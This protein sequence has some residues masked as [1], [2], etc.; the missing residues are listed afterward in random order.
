MAS[1]IKGYQRNAE[2]YERRW[3]TAMREGNA[4]EAYAAQE[5]YKKNIEKQE[6]ELKKMDPNSK[7]YE[8]AERSIEEQKS[9]A[10]E[11][12]RQ[13]RIEFS[14]E[15]K[16]E[17]YQQLNA[18]NM[19]ISHDMSKAVER[20]DTASYDFLRSQYEKNIS[21]QEQLG[22][23]MKEEGVDFQDT[24][25]REKVDL[26]DH[27]IDMRNKLNEQLAEKEA[28]GKKI[29]EEERANASKYSNQVKKDEVELVKYQNDKK[30]ESMRERGA[31][32]EEIKA[33]EE[34]NK[35]SEEWVR[36]INS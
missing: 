1:G 20:G 31:S 36:K 28:K 34:Q 27:D 6:E 13:Q 17:A 26:Q 12:G 19:Q 3:N 4:S 14:G 5:D 22:R 25:H 24:V 10:W 33:E 8:K 29:S 35:Q 7:D 15:E 11:M 2:A 9:N 21:S 23:Q 30:I 16:Q 32:S 18:K